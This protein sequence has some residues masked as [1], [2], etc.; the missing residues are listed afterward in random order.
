LPP[1][2]PPRRLASA[3]AGLLALVTAACAHDFTV[4]NRET[5]VHVWL[6]APDLGQAG[7]TIDALIYVG[8]RK[9]VQGPVTFP[10]GTTHVSLPTVHVPTCPTT[11]SAVLRGGALTAPRQIRVVGES[12]VQVVVRG[13]TVTIEYFREQPN[14]CGP[15]R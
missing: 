11:A 9:V 14:V 8:A 2:R 13:D 5:P 7:G 12:W 10:P 6:S 15:T 1:P 4:E 3:L